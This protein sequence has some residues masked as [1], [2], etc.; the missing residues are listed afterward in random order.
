MKYL[1]YLVLVPNVIAIMLL[2]FNKNFSKR[3]NLKKAIPTLLIYIILG[4]EIICRHNI[5][6]FFSKNYAGIGWAI[7][8]YTLVIFLISPFFIL[9]SCNIKR[10]K[11]VYDKWW[12][13][14]LLFILLM[15]PFLLI[16]W[17][18]VLLLKLGY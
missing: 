13:K 11:T 15:V 10:G 8:L 14:I 6:R 17:G 2:I 9:Y 16:V 7:Y 18:K 5:D 4:I 3:Y 1:W 12:F